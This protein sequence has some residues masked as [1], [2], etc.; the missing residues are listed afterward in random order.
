MK[1]VEFYKLPSGKC[2]VDNHLDSLT[3]TQITKIAW[4]LK[5]I[6][7]LDQVPTKYFKKLVGT[8][9][10]GKLEQMLGKTLSEFWVFCTVR[11]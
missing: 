1:V 3:D 2:P 6:R 11:I 7:E 4:V 9:D 5:L 10:I 8:D